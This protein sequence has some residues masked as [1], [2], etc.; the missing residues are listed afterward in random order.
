MALAMLV[1]SQTSTRFLECELFDSRYIP[2][3]PF[4]LL[5]VQEAKKLREDRV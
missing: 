3:P 2:E 4:Y 1:S 5:A